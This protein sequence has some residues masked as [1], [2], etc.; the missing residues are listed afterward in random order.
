[1]NWEKNKGWITTVIAVLTTGGGG[2]LI[3]DGATYNAKEEVKKELQVKIDEL[4]DEKGK[5]EDEAI[6]LGF[7][8]DQCCSGGPCTE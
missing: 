3:L 5:L 8:Y 2:K 4:E 1:M 6:I 7:R